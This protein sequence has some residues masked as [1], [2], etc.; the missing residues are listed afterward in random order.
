MAKILVGIDGSE[1]SRR[2][3]EHLLKMLQAQ[4]PQEVHLLN[5]QIPVESGHARMFVT[6]K[7]L[8]DYYRDE[9]IAALKEAREMLDGAG[10]PYQHHVAVGHVA[11]TI[12]AYAKQHGF[13]EIVIG[14]HGRGALRHLLLGSVATDVLR[15][16]E[17]PVTLVK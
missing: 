3:I 9:G 10:V 6:E 13:D 1:H 5:V 4:G 7:Q 8:Q 2:S 16:S 14:S 15:L 11:Q 17:M 12:A